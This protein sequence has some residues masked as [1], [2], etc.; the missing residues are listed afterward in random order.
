MVRGGGEV[1]TE[2]RIGMKIFL[3]ALYTKQSKTKTLTEAVSWTPG[4]WR[5][6]DE[7]DIYNYFG[8]IT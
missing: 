7:R 4:E 6:C 3:K 5:R 2:A 8:S 1:D